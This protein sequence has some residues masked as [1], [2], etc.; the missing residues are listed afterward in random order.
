MRV[1]YAVQH[2]QHQP[3]ATIRRRLRGG[4]PRLRSLRARL[5]VG[6]GRTCLKA[7]QQLGLRH[8]DDRPRPCPGR[9]FASAPAPA[10]PPT[11]PAALAGAVAARAQHRRRGQQRG[12]PARACAGYRASVGEPPRRGREQSGASRWYPGA[13]HRGGLSDDGG[14]QQH[15]HGPETRQ[16][17]P[18]RRRGRAARAEPPRV[19]PPSPC[20]SV[21]QAGFGQAPACTAR[22]R[23]WS[24]GGRI[25]AARLG[26]FYYYLY[27]GKPDGRTRVQ[28]YTKFTGERPRRFGLRVNAYCAAPA[29]RGACVWGAPDLAR[30]RRRPR[31]WACN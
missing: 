19:A 21:R 5:Q 6:R 22:G 4:S 7:G 1:H 23:A 26:F 31:G 17:L 16:K 11:A 27:L 3:L 29:G 25:R 8:L 9:V 30:R 15:Q 12:A 18:P 13:P 20:G 2:D 14:F 28:L 10:A 24:A